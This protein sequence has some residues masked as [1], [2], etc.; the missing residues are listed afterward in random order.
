MVTASVFSQKRFFKRVKV[1]F[2]YW[3]KRV[4]PLF[5]PAFNALTAL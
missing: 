5:T 2:W 4:Y 1:G 3:E